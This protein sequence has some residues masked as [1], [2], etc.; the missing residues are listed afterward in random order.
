MLWEASCE[1]AL[2]GGAYSREPHNCDRS[3]SA[4]TF[5]NGNEIKN[6]EH[7]RTQL[8]PIRPGSAFFRVDGRPDVA[9]L[10]PA[11]WAAAGTR[12]G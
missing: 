2:G 6:R 1:R 3:L 9:K 7:R 5:A 4:I 11:N 10:K 12:G 8:E